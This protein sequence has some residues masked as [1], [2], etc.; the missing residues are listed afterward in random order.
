MEDEE[1]VPYGEDF[2]DAAV[3]AAWADAVGRKR[4]WRPT[5]FEHF[6]AIVFIDIRRSTALF[7]KRLHGFG[8]LFRMLSFDEIGAAAMMSRA[9]AGTGAA[10]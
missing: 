6:V 1:D 3:A 8:E 9:T 5:I 2:H 4:P 10:P 7:E